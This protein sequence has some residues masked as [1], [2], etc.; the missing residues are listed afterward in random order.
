MSNF[1]EE[2]KP[3]RVEVWSEIL[4]QLKEV[5]E[6]HLLHCSKEYVE[7]KRPQSLNEGQSFQKPPLFPSI[8]FLIAQLHL[9]QVLILLEPQKLDT[10]RKDL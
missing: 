1:D 4:M 5:A 6:L 2:Y 3:G 10:F 8:L 7:A 9:L